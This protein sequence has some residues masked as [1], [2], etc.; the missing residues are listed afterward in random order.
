MGVQ[1]ETR[2]HIV[3]LLD[4][5]VL[6]PEVTL[7]ATPAQPGVANPWDAWPVWDFSEVAG[8]TGE[9]LTTHWFVF[10]VVPSG[11]RQGALIPAGDLIAETVA[12]YLAGQLPAR[13]ERLEPIQLALENSGTQPAVRISLTY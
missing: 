10:V 11:D 4:G 8:F 1:A 3:Q 12:P 6:T 7:N 13:I 2:D 5:Y 9:Q